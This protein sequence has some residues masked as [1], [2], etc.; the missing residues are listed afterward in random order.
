M[1]KSLFLIHDDWVSF[2]HRVSVRC[3]H[4]SVPYLILCVYFYFFA[5]EDLDKLMQ[6][7][8]EQEMEVRIHGDGNDGLSL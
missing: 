8:R 4:L 1:S 5:Q 2:S 6:R 3:I 7:I